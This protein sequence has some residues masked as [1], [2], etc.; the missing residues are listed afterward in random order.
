MQ[1]STPLPDY[2]LQICT[3]SGARRD[4]ATVPPVHGIEKALDPHKK[5]EH[6]SPQPVAPQPPTMSGPYPTQSSIRKPSPVVAASRK[7]VGCSIKT[8]NK[9]KHS[10]KATDKIPMKMPL[11]P[12]EAPLIPQ[13][14]PLNPNTPVPAFQPQQG[15]SPH[16]PKTVPNIAPSG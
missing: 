15:S 9:N 11:P 5:P 1:M 3:C 14:Y 7:L 10:S 8:L 2:M 13:F 16:S 6:Q 12:P 4:S